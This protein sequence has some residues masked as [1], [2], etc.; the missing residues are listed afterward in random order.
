MSDAVGV[1]N[2]HI[3]LLNEEQQ[4]AQIVGRQLDNYAELM[5]ALGGGIK[6]DLP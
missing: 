2:A 3:A 5:A 6:L 4:Q 1:I